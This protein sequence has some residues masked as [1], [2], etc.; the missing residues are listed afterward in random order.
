M[1]KNKKFCVYK[2]E[3]P[4][5]KVYIGITSRKPKKRWVNGEGYNN[6]DYFTKA[7]KKYG[8]ENFKHE[9]LYTNLSKDEACEK[10]KELI[11]YYD[12]TNRDKGY[13]ITPGGEYN[14]A[15]EEGRKRISSANIGRVV[16]KKTRIQI[17]KTKTGV[18]MRED[19]KK[20]ISVIRK[21]MHLHMT[22]EHRK[23]I[24]EVNTG[25]EMSEETRDKIRKGLE[26]KSKSVE[27]RKKL[28]ESRKGRYMGKDNPIAEA[29]RCIETGEIYEC[30]S[31]ADRKLNVS[32]GS[33]SKCIVGKQKSVR[34]FH[35]EKIN[36]VGEEMVV[37][38]ERKEK[39]GKFAKRKPI[40]KDNP[41]AKVV[42]CIETGEIYECM[43]DA[44]RKLKVSAGSVA[45]C[46]SGRQKSVKGLH[47][48]RII[49]ERT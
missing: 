27:H 45:K 14:S 4:S 33:V 26:G 25:K 11:K 43:S 30:M 41:A 9:I 13:N 5:H 40:G 39:L 15:S 47:F 8:W 28:S 2:H 17:S 31:D 34:G 7:I 3:S 42:R 18:P 29:V 46:I 16:S 22:E 48:E 10:E 44:D 37:F 49:E 21:K 24:S 1:D 6:N 23:K 35:F 38:T 12:S 32:L 20:K 36:E 19:T